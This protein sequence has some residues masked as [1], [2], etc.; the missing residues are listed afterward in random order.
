MLV[1]PGLCPIPAERGVPGRSPG[2][3]PQSLV[4]RSALGPDRFIQLRLGLAV[5]PPLPTD[6]SQPDP[7][8][9]TQR[10]SGPPKPSEGPAAGCHPPPPFGKPFCQPGSGLTSVCWRFS[11]LR[12]GKGT[13]P[14][15]QP[16]AGTVFSA[17]EWSKWGGT[18]APTQEG[19]GSGALPRRGG[20]RDRRAGPCRCN[21]HPVPGLACATRARAE[22]PAATLGPGSPA[23][24]Q[25][26]RARNPPPHRPRSITP[27]FCRTRSCLSVCPCR[28]ARGVAG[29]SLTH[30]LNQD[31]SYLASP[32]PAWPAHP[33]GC[34]NHAAPS[35][36]RF[37]AAVRGSV[38]AAHSPPPRAA[39]GIRAKPP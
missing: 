12:G 21:R 10:P 26:A 23:G 33:R 4:P 24:W 17:G 9:R 29:T 19:S 31:W 18:A 13:K 2:V 15:A 1:A 32:R 14:P 22:S 7:H 28:G 36:P 6:A 8:G 35:P 5:S 20:F 25:P 11:L 3:M 37:S 27:G 39:G 38:Q 30:P 34:R 16:G